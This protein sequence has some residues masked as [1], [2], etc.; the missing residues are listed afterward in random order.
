MKCKNLVLVVILNG[1]HNYTNYMNETITLKPLWHQNRK[2]IAIHFNYNETIK[3]YIKKFPD[4][5]WSQ[6]H[7][8]FYTPFENEKV[9]QLFSYLRLKQ[10][11]VDYEAFK[12]TEPIINTINK[13]VRHI[14]LPGLNE[15]QEVNILKYKKWL[16]QKRFSENTVNTYVEVTGLFFRYINLKKIP[17]IT[18][19]AI[20]QF[21]YDFIFNAGKSVS[22]QNQCI[23]GIKH[24]ITFRGIAID[25]LQIER[26]KKDKKLPIVLSKNEVKAIFEATTNLKH[27]ALLSLIYSAGLRIGEALN[28]KHKDI[29]IQRG[30]IHIKAAKGKKDRYTLLS[31]GIIP[32]LE[33][34][35]QHYNPKV[36]LFE[37][38]SGKVYTQVSA[39][40]VFKQ[41]LNKAEIKKHATLHTLRH[42]FA[43]HLLESGT[44]IRYIQ[45]LLGHNS[46][47]T[48]MIYTHVSTTNLTDIKNPFDNL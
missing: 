43:T 4:V 12:K 25:T 8:L 19:R 28:L 39:R 33:T 13:P 1:Y 20:E 5:R 36:Y 22:Y 29:D 41:S 42:S 15:K 35:I 10:W 38:R 23:S 16:E 3:E 11:Y 24:Y 30:L 6:T 40:Q 2:Q 31:K 45:E 44:D 46:P 27:K 26:P 17:A 32:L 34:Y 37:G 47:K 18:S 48:T 14:K 7:K 21:N 9:H